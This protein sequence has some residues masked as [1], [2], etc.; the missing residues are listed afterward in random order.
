MSG[1]APIRRNTGAGRTNREVANLNRRF[2]SQQSK[3]RIRVICV[4]PAKPSFV[5]ATVARSGRF[6]VKEIQLS[7]G[8][9]ESLREIHFK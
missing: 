1:V 5:P 7:P 6:C 2:L 8:Y 9:A 3:K 4:L